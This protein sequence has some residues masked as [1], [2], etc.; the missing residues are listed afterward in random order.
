MTT[1]NLTTPE[2]RTVAAEA[3]SMFMHRRKVLKG[4]RPQGHVVMFSNGLCIKHDTKLGVRAV[5]VE[6]ADIYTNKTLSRMANWGFGVPAYRNGNDELA[7]LVARADAIAL[8]IANLEAAI[9]SLGGG[10]L[11]IEPVDPEEEADED[12]IAL[13]TAPAEGDAPGEE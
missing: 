7:R 1:A 6:N 2:A 5:S 13:D 11:L 9:T 8:T 4:L 12:F 3:I 10:D